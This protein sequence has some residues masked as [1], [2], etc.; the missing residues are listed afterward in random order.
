MKDKM[1]SKDLELEKGREF[2]F[3][4]LTMPHVKRLRN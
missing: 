1:L 2:A 4:D 3:G